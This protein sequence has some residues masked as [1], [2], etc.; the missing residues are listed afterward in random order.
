[1]KFGNAIYCLDSRSIPLLHR[2]LYLQLC[3]RVHQATM[4]NINKQPIVAQEICPYYCLRDCGNNE[5]PF[6]HLA[7][8]EIKGYKFL[9][10]G[11]DDGP[12]CCEKLERSRWKML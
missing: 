8:S 12:I 5:W 2:A 9:T 4:T 11:R 3:Q 7:K 6:K 1:M 10:V